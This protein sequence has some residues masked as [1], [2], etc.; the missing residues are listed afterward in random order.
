MRL[1]ELIML[2]EILEREQEAVKEYVS[3]TREKLKTLERELD[4]PELSS[5]QEAN[6]EGMISHY[7][8]QLKNRM[9]SLSTVN[10]LLNIVNNTE[11]TLG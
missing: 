4:N 2:Q 9:N 6:L 10:S 7:N 1:K 11:F 3:I 5:E 8:D